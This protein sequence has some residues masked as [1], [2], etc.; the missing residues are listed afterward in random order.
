VLNIA[1]CADNNIGEDESIYFAIYLVDGLDMQGEQQKKLSEL[2]L[3]QEPVLTDKDL[4]EY[5]WSTHEFKLRDDTETAKAFL[6][7][8]KIGNVPVS[9]RS[10]VV[11]CENER[12]Y[13]GRFHSLLSSTFLTQTPFITELFADDSSIRINYANLE[14]DE[15]PRDDERIY[16]VLRKLGKLIEEKLLEDVLFYEQAA[17]KVNILISPTSLDTRNLYYYVPDNQ[18][19]LSNMIDEVEWSEIARFPDASYRIGIK[20]IYDDVEWEMVS[21]GTFYYSEDHGLEY[22]GFQGENKELYNRILQ[23]LKD[24]LDFAPFDPKQISDIVSAEVTYT[25]YRS[26]KTYIQSIEDR[27]DLQLIEERIRLAKP[28]GGITACPLNEAV[29]T[30]ENEDG[31][32]MLIRLAS[33][34]CPIYFANGICFDYGGNNRDVL[35]LFDEIPWRE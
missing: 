3:S 33:D 9:G 8:I 31:T 21:N 1:G 32:V 35:N 2:S 23:L 10:F 11:V 14:G 16:N 15:D 7:I 17:E 18:Q 19:Q 5:N 25:P 30:L 12:I 26:D 29:M 20:I 27:N 22:K 6:E 24:N 28:L 13:K 4:I 34:S